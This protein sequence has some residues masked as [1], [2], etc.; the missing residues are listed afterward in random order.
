M[1]LLLLS[2]IT[3]NATK[4]H[5]TEQEMY[6]VLAHLLGVSSRRLILTVPYEQEPEVIY[7]HRQLF[8]RAK[9]EA[10]G[11]WCIQQLG[12]AGRMWCEDCEGGLLLVERCP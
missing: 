9:L 10:V 12:G 5:F 4:P 8:T 1:L 7:D 6:R 3:E 2:R 11:Q